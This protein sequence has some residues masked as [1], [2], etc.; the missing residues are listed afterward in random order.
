MGEGADQ[1]IYNA[2]LHE[3]IV[4]VSITGLVIRVPGGWIYVVNQAPV[5][6]PF[7]NE[8]QEVK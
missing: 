5:F 8:F 7:N 6:V 1:K 2:K 4:D 3:E